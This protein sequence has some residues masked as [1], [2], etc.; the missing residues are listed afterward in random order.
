M[1]GL[2]ARA[3]R[4][5][6][7]ATLEGGSGLVGGEIDVVDDFRPLGLGVVHGEAVG[8]IASAALEKPKQARLELVGPMSRHGNLH[9]RQ[10]PLLIQHR[11]AVR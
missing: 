3:L 6:R 2:G 11:V 9:V 8:V 1:L 4:F 7:P 5:P 10:V